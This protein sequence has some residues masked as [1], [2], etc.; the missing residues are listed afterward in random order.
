MNH[1]A[2]EFATLMA[3]TDDV[4]RLDPA[5]FRLTGKL[6]ADSLA[7][8]VRGENYQTAGTSGGVEYGPVGSYGYYRLRNP[9]LLLTPQYPLVFTSAAGAEV[10]GPGDLPYD[11]GRDWSVMD[12]SQSLIF[13][14]NKSS[15][16][17]NGLLENYWWSWWNPRFGFEEPTAIRGTPVQVVS[18]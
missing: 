15:I 10:Y 8:Y 16:L 17:T 6:A 14:A 12:A 18:S 5:S 2:A 7:E 3:M 11:E 9:G 13:L 4:L 1:K